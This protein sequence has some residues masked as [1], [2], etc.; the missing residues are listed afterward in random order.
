[1][2]NLLRSLARKYC[3]RSMQ[4]SKSDIKIKKSS[5]EI[6]GSTSW[7]KFKKT[8]RDYNF[9]QTKVIFKSWRFYSPWCV[10][11]LPNPGLSLR[12]N[13]PETAILRKKSSRMK[14]WGLHSPMKKKSSPCKYSTWRK[15][16]RNSAEKC[17]SR[18]I[19]RLAKMS[20]ISPTPPQ[21]N[22]SHRR[23]IIMME[24]SSPEKSND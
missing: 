18:I 10:K 2:T 14:V 6:C 17:V 12:F 7:C 13:S 4:N 5:L 16:W 24:L 21:E 23:R 20:W 3:H 1:M 11:F 22:S 8:T 19:I 9:F 15:K